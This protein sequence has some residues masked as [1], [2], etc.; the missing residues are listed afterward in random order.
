MSGYGPPKIFGGEDRKEGLGALHGELRRIA[1]HG[2]A[3]VALA[4][5]AFIP[6]RE[7]KRLLDTG[8]FRQAAASGIIGGLE[9]YFAQI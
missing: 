9:R 7:E 4:E 1:A 2:D 6:N 8:W 3:C 5:V